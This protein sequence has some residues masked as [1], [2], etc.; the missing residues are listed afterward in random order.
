MSRY[1]IGS[2]VLALALIGSAAAQQWSPYASLFPNTPCMDGWSGCVV[3]TVVH[4]NGTQLDAGKHVLPAGARVGWWD[5]QPTV[6]FSPFVAL[7]AYTGVP[8]Q[9]VAQASPP[10]E[11]APVERPV[12]VNDVQPDRPAQAD[13]SA[14]APVE[15][16]VT[17]PVER[18]VAVTPTPVPTPTVATPAPAGSMRPSTTPVPAPLPPP[19][20]TPN[21]QKTVPPTA[22]VSPPVAPTPAPMPSP[23]AVPKPTPTTPAVVS[24]APGDNSCDDLG[25]L[26]PNA[27]MGQLTKGQSTCLEGRIATEPAQT[28]RDKVSRLLINNAYAKGDK[29]EWERLMKRHL[30]QIDRS[31]PDMC[32]NYALQLS[33]GGVARAQGVIRWADYAL[34]NKSRWTGNTYK[35]RVFNLLKMKAEAATRLWESAEK[36]YTEN[37]TDENNAQSEKYRGMAKE[38]AREWLDYAKASAQDTSKAMAMCVSASGNQSFCDGG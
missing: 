22:S 24:V 14:V 7:S 12:A 5:L 6:V 15:R 31:D 33:R 8:G 17:A 28:T 10:P 18:P 29:A 16:P 1:F 3:G 20:A 27:L 9:V 38:Y 11:A 19:V 37:R 23:M 30:E 25:A 36:E 21:T 34:E 32:Y 2:T 35:T 4:G 26:E 13:R